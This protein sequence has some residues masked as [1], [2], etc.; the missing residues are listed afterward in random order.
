MYTIRNNC[1]VKRHDC[2]LKE[3]KVHKVLDK[4]IKV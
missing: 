2:K 4:S 3:N 1:K